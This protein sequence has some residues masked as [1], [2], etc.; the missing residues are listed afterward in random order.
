MPLLDL[1]RMGS[2]ISKAVP[3]ANVKNQAEAEMYKD[4]S[5][6]GGV[7]ANIGLEKFR[8]QRE[9][10]R[11]RE[12]SSAREEVVSQYFQKKA[13]YDTEE[14]RALI[15]KDGGIIDAEVTGTSEPM[16]YDTY[17]N[18]YLKFH[19]DRV[20][21]DRLENED[22]GYDQ[23][24]DF[25]FR[26]SLQGFKEDELVKNLKSSE[27]V[28][29]DSMKLV[30]NGYTDNVTRKILSYPPTADVIDRVWEDMQTYNLNY[31]GWAKTH[32]AFANFADK[33]FNNKVGEALYNNIVTKFSSN[34]PK[35]AEQALKDVSRLA[36]DK[37]RWVQ[38]KD[39]TKAIISRQ[40]MDEL[41]AADPNFAPE[42]DLT[43]IQL[44]D[45]AF[46]QEGFISPEEQ[47]RIAK[48]AQTTPVASTI[49]DQQL[50]HLM[51]LAIN[52]QIA[53]KQKDSSSIR[54]QLLNLTDA[55]KHREHN[56]KEV[57]A[58]II[59]LIGANP[60][61]IDKMEAFDKAEILKN[62][63]VS[64]ADGYVSKN[65]FAN[66]AKIDV[67]YKDMEKMILDKAEMF[68]PDDKELKSLLS[69]K[70]QMQALVADAQAKL[71]EKAVGRQKQ[72]IQDPG[73]Y[74]LANDPTYLSLANK[75]KAAKDKVTMSSAL[76]QM[77]DRGQKLAK[78]MNHDI[79]RYNTLPREV[80]NDLSERLSETID[81]KNGGEFLTSLKDATTK[82]PYQF[83]QIVNQLDKKGKLSP[84]QIASLY[85]YDLG[86]G[87]AAEKDAKLK[88]FLKRTDP[89]NIKVIEEKLKLDKGD[90]S[91]LNE[92][93]QETIDK[94]MSGANFI[95]NSDMIEM[96]Q[97]LKDLY[98]ITVKENMANGLDEDVAKEKANKE[99]FGKVKILNSNS[100]KGIAN[101]SMFDNSEI[102]AE[103]WAKGQIK[104]FEKKLKE[105]KL[106]PNYSNY[107]EFNSLYADSPLMKKENK[108]EINS[109]FLDTF[110]SFTFVN[111]DPTGKTA[112]FE[113]WGVQS[114]N[115]E[116][117]KIYLK[118][119]KGKVLQYIAPEPKKMK[120]ENIIKASRSP[121]S[122][123]KE[124]EDNE[125]QNDLYFESLL[126]GTPIENVIPVRGM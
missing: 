111:A 61:V 95:R 104:E 112:K 117:V 90:K 27:N 116:P 46:T 2:E 11:F 3:E 55:Y 100:I 79:S 21:K 75:L 73:G 14:G 118:D 48:G 67:L 49:N 69:D 107:N 10:E 6:F 7:V 76:Q 29:L 38:T 37:L 51:R 57:D 35:E 82:D 22:N 121:S 15:A 86:G 1:G 89:E 125:I 25:T 41:L 120:R 81:L 36:G 97:K 92:H 85:A 31:E 9:I 114:K 59:N 65:R 66:P 91:D 56:P 122:I 47:Y 40:T 101:A 16:A 84:A 8:R 72:I 108:A 87:T 60:S 80:M 115:K 64:Y 24:A 110:D 12:V 45:N 50:N 5:R 23:E 124:L 99:L 70:P 78:G 44:E 62:A 18:S 58:S 63:A 106:V 93:A 13:F 74:M 42:T 4:L 102:D 19:T 105:G 20:S 103:G 71:R 17:F 113:L 109:K 32:P 33:D 26:Q 52:Q 53:L 68:F 126:K 30:H 39:G 43:D 96:N 94:L 54:R 34:D 77:I 123:E 88:T 119:S 83:V 28:F 98:A